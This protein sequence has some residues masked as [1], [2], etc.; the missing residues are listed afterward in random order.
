MYKLAIWFRLSNNELPTVCP[1]FKDFSRYN[2][3]TSY[4]SKTKRVEPLILIRLLHFSSLPR[5]GIV[6]INEG[7]NK[8]G[9][10]YANK[11]LS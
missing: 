3:M 4:P 10:Y 11:T 1:L 2:E 7:Y 6:K 9:D 8:D 5:F